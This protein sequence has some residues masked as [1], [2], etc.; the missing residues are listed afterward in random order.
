MVRERN[1]QDGREDNT[2]DIT[3]VRQIERNNSLKQTWLH[4]PTSIKILF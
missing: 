2:S 1:R 4:I 3:T